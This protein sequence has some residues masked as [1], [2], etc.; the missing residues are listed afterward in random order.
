MRTPAEKIRDLLVGYPWRKSDWAV[1]QRFEGDINSLHPNVPLLSVLRLE[2][3]SRRTHEHSQERSELLRSSSMIAF[4]TATAY[5]YPSA[6]PRNGD[7]RSTRAFPNLI[8]G[9]LPSF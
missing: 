5:T 7:V 2:L 6:L 3:F 9:S 8:S 1:A 4:L